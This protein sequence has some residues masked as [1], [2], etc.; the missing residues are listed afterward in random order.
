VSTCPV[1]RVIHG[2]IVCVSG[3]WTQMHTDELV[4]QGTVLLVQ[5]NAFSIVSARQAIGF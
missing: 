2:E 5:T 4:Q 3:E 1:H